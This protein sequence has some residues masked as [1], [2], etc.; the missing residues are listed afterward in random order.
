MGET[1][2]LPVDVKRALRRLKEKERCAEG[3]PTLDDLILDSMSRTMAGLGALSEAAG[4]SMSPVVKL[5]NGGEL[6]IDQ[7][8]P[9]MPWKDRLVQI[10]AIVQSIAQDGEVSEMA[11]KVMLADGW[12]LSGGRIKTPMWLIDHAEMTAHSA[13]K[14]EGLEWLISLK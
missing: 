6:S 3:I 14:V 10:G 13:S 9:N 5:S 11:R 8:D 7:G 12:V 1:R 2:G 4:H